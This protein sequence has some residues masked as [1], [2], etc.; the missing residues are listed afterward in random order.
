MF[1]Y[2]G[3]CL[4]T[5][6]PATLCPAGRQPAGGC[7]SSAA[8][9][10]AAAV[11][12]CSNFS[13]KQLGRQRRSARGVRGRGV[14]VVGCLALSEAGTAKRHAGSFVVCVG[15]DVR[16]RHRVGLLNCMQKAGQT[17]VCG[18]CWPCVLQAGSW[19]GAYFCF[20]LCVWGGVSN[21]M[22][23]PYMYCRGLVKPTNG[24]RRWGE[25]CACLS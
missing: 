19:S 4:C 20:L 23:H 11:G 9:I 24:R 17:F 18:H 8:A 12:A 7:G 14:G 2:A 3:L 6:D 25:H 5:T 1:R 16:K 15:S 22:H 10:A 13:G 21:Q